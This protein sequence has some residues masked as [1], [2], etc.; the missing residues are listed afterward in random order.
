VAETVLVPT[1]YRDS[2]YMA[3]AVLQKSYYDD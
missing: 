2:P 1:V 3:I